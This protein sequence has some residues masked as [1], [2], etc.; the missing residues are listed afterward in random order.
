MINYLTDII[1]IVDRRT[2]WALIVTSLIVSILEASSISAVIP[3]LNIIL[4]DRIPDSLIAFLQAVGVNAIATQK[5]AILFAIVVV[6]LLRALILSGILFF[7]SSLVFG[8]QTRLSNLLYGVYLQSRFEALSK[9]STTEITKASTTDLANLTGGVLLPMAAMCSE[10]ALVVGAIFVLL[11]VQPTT[12]LALIA[13]TIILATPV[14]AMNNKRLSHLGR[15]RHQM[16][17]DRTRFAQ[18]MTGSIREVKVYK[19]ESQL[20]SAI[21]DTNI[22][23]SHVMTRINF[24][25]NFPRIYFEAAGLS[26]LL[27]ICGIQ[28]YIGLSSTEILTF[29]MI[30]GFSAFRALPSIAKILAQLQILRFYRPTLTSF[31]NLLDE[32]GAT[33]GA[34]KV[35]SSQCSDSHRNDSAAAGAIRIVAHDASYTYSDGLPHVFQNVS[36]ELRSGQII[37]LVGQ[38]GIGKSTLLDCII[39]LRGLSGGS[40]SILDDKERVSTKV[41]VAYVPQTPVIFEAT[42]WRNLTLEQKDPIDKPIMDAKVM[43]ALSISGFGEIMQARDLE[44]LSRITES[45]RNLSGGQ[46]QRLALARA[47][48]R[49]GNLLVLDEATSAIDVASENKIYEEI[50]NGREE[51]IV[52]IVTH[53]PQLLKYCDQVIEM[54]PGGKVSV[55]VKSVHRGTKN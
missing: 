16:E 40:I 33:H 30:S 3:A 54:L 52:I 22:A 51:R 49:Q 45:G 44:M 12:A 28:L 15:V 17:G 11:L 36:F 23:Y 26:V 2:L 8:A 39:G 31:L 10:L 41:K 1:R 27:A 43:Q 42:V 19:M 35:A 20:L 5:M 47:L 13:I 9:V 4:T 37:G 14:L 6:F 7:Q 32:L 18:E 21:D 25:Q 48:V 24:L 55:N 53:R 34:V 29:I 50:F 38:S 46:R